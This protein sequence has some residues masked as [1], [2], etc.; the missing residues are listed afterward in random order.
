MTR[1]DLHSLNA[2]QRPLGSGQGCRTIRSHF[3]PSPRRR[4]LA[5]LVRQRITLSVNGETK[6]DAHLF[7]PDLEGRGTINHLSGFTTWRRVT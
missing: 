2:L 3:R 5:R 1:R 6:Q 4:N 7:R